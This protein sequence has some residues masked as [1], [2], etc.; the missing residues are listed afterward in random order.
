MVAILVHARERASEQAT[1]Q[2]AL[3]RMSCDRTL[4]NYVA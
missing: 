2:G 1:E 4:H 3:R